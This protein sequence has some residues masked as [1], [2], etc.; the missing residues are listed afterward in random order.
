M[1]SI[2]L[3]MASFIVIELFSLSTLIFSKGNVI[4]IS[5]HQNIIHVSRN[6]EI[7]SFNVNNSNYI[8][9]KIYCIKIF[10]NKMN[11]QVT[12]NSKN[13]DFSINSNFFSSK[14]LG[15]VIINKKVINKR[16]SGGGFFTSKNGIFNV[17]TKNRPL[18]VDFSS[19]THL[20]GII[21][22]KL[23]SNVF[24][25]E[26][27]KKQFYRMLVGKDSKNNLL[28]LHSD[29]YALISIEDICKV[30]KKNGIVTGLIF[31]GGSSVDVNLNDEMFNH[32]FQA[33]PTI[34][35]EFKK[36]TTPPIYIVGNFK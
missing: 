35:R 4:S 9:G 8:D 20:I 7:S 1:K 36:N 16:S 26:W 30:G 18:D 25:A 24:K 3:I 10:K 27:A 31:D 28:I 11:F 19:Q 17:T 15:E 13:F 22:G 23:N 21:N 14:P 33:L 29:R 12:E 2:F 34:L 5:N 6:C 32:S